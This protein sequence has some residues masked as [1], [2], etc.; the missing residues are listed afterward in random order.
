ML[1]LGHDRLEL[2]QAFRLRVALHLALQADEIDD[3]PRIIM[4]RRDEQRVQKAFTIGAH[5]VQH[6]GMF[7]A[8]LDGLAQIG[9]AGL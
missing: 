3:V 5:V 6:R 2:L 9:H 8:L 1:D 4:D 7:I